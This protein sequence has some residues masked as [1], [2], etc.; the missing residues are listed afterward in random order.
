MNSH[1]IAFVSTSEEMPSSGG[2]KFYR[3]VISKVAEIVSNSW[4]QFLLSVLH[5]TLILFDR[6]FLPLHKPQSNTSFLQ[7]LW[8][9]NCTFCCVFLSLEK[10]GLPLPSKILFSK[11]DSTSINHFPNG[12]TCFKMLIQT[13]S[14]ALQHNTSYYCQDA[15]FRYS[16]YTSQAWNVI[17]LE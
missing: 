6:W 10:S 1:V 9:K 14:F 17:Q 8:E 4:L 5:Q 15:W 16:N 7:A 3:D 12:N 13:T 2:S 11:R